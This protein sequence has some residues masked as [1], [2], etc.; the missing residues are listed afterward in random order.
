MSSVT[1]CC[2]LHSCFSTKILMFGLICGPPSFF[3]LLCKY[4]KVSRGVKTFRINKKLI[5]V[6]LW[7]LVFCS[8]VLTHITGIIVAS[9]CCCSTPGSMKEAKRKAV[10][11]LENMNSQ[12]KEV[13]SHLH[14]CIQVHQKQAEWNL[15]LPLLLWVSLHVFL[16]PVLHSPHFSLY[17]PLSSRTTAHSLHMGSDRHFHS[18]PATQPG[19]SNKWEHAARMH[20]LKVA[21]WIFKC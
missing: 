10:E 14:H 19:Y 13:Y 8:F 11:P 12:K 2:Y 5:T 16:P 21:L 7:T 4:R 18:R 17:V 1:A 20:T 9:I 6:Q 15:S 3:S